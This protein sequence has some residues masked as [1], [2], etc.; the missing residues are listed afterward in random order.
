MPAV[1][2]IIPCYNEE[3]TIGLLLGAILRQTYPTSEVEVVIADGLSTDQTRA[4][5]L[6]FQKENPWLVVK[7]VDN[8]RR[9]IPAALNTAL[10]SAS[11][12]WII[13]LDGHST[14]APDYI[15]RCV[16]ALRR[17]KGDVVG[18]VWQ[19]EPGGPGWVAR[20]IALAAA[21][22]LGVGDALYRFTTHAAAVDTVPFGAFSREL[23]ERVGKFDES[24]LT[25][26]DYELNTRVRQAGGRIWLDPAIRSRYFARA[27]LG[28]L[29][30]QYFRYG[31]WKLRMLRRYPATLR[32]R[33][34]LPPVFV[35]VLAALAALAPFWDVARILLLVQTSLYLLVLLAGALPVALRK[36]DARLLVGLP[37]AIA[38]M[39]LAW[40]G[41][42]WISLLKK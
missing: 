14:P 5:I 32:W 34:A 36:K 37:L 11:G 42:F 31:F 12:E 28:A 18:G 9:N 22:P 41:G 1:S 39:H 16:T 35:L 30:R 40:G 24:L 29:A 3:K 15:E 23:F 20:S 21:H 8:P 7:L 38:T 25:N 27:S 2:I 13:R 4:V 19:I 10:A 26:E 17:G 33:Q 6:A